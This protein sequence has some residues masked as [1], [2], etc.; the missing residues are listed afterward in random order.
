MSLG[1]DSIIYGWGITDANS[2]GCYCHTAKVTTTIRSPKGRTQTASDIYGSRGHE[3]ARADVRLLWDETDLGDYTE[4][5]THW[6]FCPYC[7][8]YYVNG[9]TTST[10]LK[11]GVSHV[12]FYRPIYV[13]SGYCSYVRK[14]PCGSNCR[15]A[16]ASVYVGG[17]A[18]PAYEYGIEPW[19]YYDGTFHCLTINEYGSS[20]ETCTCFD[21]PPFTP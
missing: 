16:T 11:L 8:C 7:N 18:C 9:Q 3:Y 12:C 14:D 1:T 13:G 5:S 4:S 6:A 15:A 19:A 2:G 17:S 21:V 20:D 10:Y